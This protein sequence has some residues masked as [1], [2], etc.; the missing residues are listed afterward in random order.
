V[1]VP[2]ERDDRAFAGTARNVEEIGAALHDRKAAAVLH[3]LFGKRHQPTGWSDET[4]SPVDH[5]RYDRIPVGSEVHFDVV[6]CVSVHDCVGERLA[7]RK[8]QTFQVARREAMNPCEVTQGSA[9]SPCGGRKRWYAELECFMARHRMKAHEILPQCDRIKPAAAVYVLRCN[10]GSLYTGATVDLPKRVAAHHRGIASKC[11]RGRRPLALVAWWHTD[12]FDLARSHEARFKRLSR[13][14]KL[15]VLAG[16][17]AFGCPLHKAPSLISRREEGRMRYTPPQPDELDAYKAE[18]DASLIRMTTD[19][20]EIVLRLFPDDAPMHSAAFLKLVKAGF[21]DGLSFHRVEPGFV[22]QGGDPDGDGTGGPGY[23]LKS[24][25]NDRPH[26]RGTLAMARASDPN[27]AG[28][29]FYLCLADARF[30]D[31]QYTVFGEMTSGFEVLD[32]IR[33]GDVIQKVTVEPR[34]A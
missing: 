27:S 25:F 11:T 16:N 4:R 26:L 23:R 8:R 33:R 17:E 15:R 2:S 28:S 22:V 20:G 6:L 31:N 13:S 21:Y 3:E 14:E 7:Q 9:R 5:R 24:E 12:D 19:K 18:A 34:P 29:Q 10:D 32:A 1:P 30:L